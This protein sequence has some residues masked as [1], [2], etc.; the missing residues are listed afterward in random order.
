MRRTRRDTMNGG[1]GAME[2]GYPGYP[3]PE[4]VARRLRERV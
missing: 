4:S 1:G 2:D 3:H